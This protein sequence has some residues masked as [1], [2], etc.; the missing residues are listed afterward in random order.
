[1]HAAEARNAGES[2]NGSERT[3][4]HQRLKRKSGFEGKAVRIPV[5]FQGTG[6]NL[7]VRLFQG[8]CMKMKKPDN[9]KIRNKHNLKANIKANI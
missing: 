2:R 6:E 9:L 4:F 8:Y 7:N 3:Y 5:E 1:M